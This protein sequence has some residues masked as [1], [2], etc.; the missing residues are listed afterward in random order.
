[1]KSSPPLSYAPS[2]AIEAAAIEIPLRS[3][4]TFAK[5]LRGISKTVHSLAGSW[6]QGTSPEEC[7]LALASYFLSPRFA[8]YSGEDESSGHF[9]S[10]GIPKY[11]KGE[12]SVTYNRIR[13]VAYSFT[14]TASS[15]YGQTIK[16]KKTSS[17]GTSLYGKTLYWHTPCYEE[18]K[19]MKWPTT[20]YR[21][22]IWKKLIPYSAY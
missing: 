2:I 4:P 17:T 1:M 5:A 6:T 14:F 22:A 19:P 9:S 18:N 7:P 20:Y 15:N 11:N 3:S 8:L 21:K 12:S 16:R 13:I 10:L